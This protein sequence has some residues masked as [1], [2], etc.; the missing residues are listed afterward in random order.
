MRITDEALARY[1]MEINDYIL[2]EEEVAEWGNLVLDLQEAR[3]KIV[4]LEASLFIKNY[5]LEESEM[6]RQ[7]LQYAKG[8]LS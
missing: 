3:A 4:S 5:L 2:K 6:Q 8:G 1:R 7:A